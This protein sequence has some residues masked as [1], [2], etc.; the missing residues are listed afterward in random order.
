M[1]SKS[2]SMIPICND[3]TKEFGEECN[4]GVERSLITSACSKRP[5]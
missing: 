2:K 4:S 1:I 5:L 3:L